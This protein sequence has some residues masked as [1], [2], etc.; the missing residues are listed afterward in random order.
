MFPVLTGCGLFVF[1][2]GPVAAEMA[3]AVLLRGHACLFLEY[4]Y[5]MAV[6]AEAEIIRN[7]K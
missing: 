2:L 3:V 7:I 1:R 5:E 4:A 6:R